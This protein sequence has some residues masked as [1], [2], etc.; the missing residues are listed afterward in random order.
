MKKVNISLLRFRVEKRFL[1]A[2]C[3]APMTDEA[4]EMVMGRLNE[5]ISEEEE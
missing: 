4:V 5:L 1:T 2:N 3:G